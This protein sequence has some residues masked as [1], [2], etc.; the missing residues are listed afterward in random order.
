MIKLRDDKGLIT[1]I[2]KVKSHTG[3]KY[4]DAADASA[5]GVVDGDLLP[6]IIFIAADP[7]IGGLRT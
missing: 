7:P 5:G 6:D 1:H 4:N 2:G 3:V